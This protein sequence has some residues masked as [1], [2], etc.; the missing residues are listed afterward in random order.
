[1]TDMRGMLFP[2]L[3][4]EASSSGSQLPQD[5]QDRFSRI[6]SLLR[7]R[8]LPCNNEDEAAEF[9]RKQEAAALE[10]A[11]AVQEEVT[12]L[13]NGIAELEAMCASQLQS[14]GDGADGD[15]DDESYVSDEDDDGFGGMPED[16]EALLGESLVR[17][18]VELEY[19]R[20]TSNSS[21]NGDAGNQSVPNRVT[22]TRDV[23]CYD[24]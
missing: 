5:I 22:S 4:D 15:G 7:E 20:D 1:M 10:A 16:G 18:V 8:A 12:R 23:L 13:Q 11:R 6:R 3:D 24:G 2:P 21:S 17:A 19:D 9:K 14:Q